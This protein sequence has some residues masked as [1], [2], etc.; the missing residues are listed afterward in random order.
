MKKIISILLMAALLVTGF[1]FVPEKTYA[2]TK[3]ADWYF[4]GAECTSN[5]AAASTIDYIQAKHPTGSVY[6]GSGECY[7]WAEKIS[8]MLS[9]KR[10]TPIWP[11]EWKA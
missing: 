5:S 11:A 8:K 7:G 3:P 9:A 10:S 2:A 4:T 6:K 1:T